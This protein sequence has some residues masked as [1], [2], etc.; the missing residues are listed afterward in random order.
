MEEIVIAI[1]VKIYL[2]VEPVQK[3]MQMVQPPLYEEIPK[4][5]TTGSDGERDMVGK[6]I[7]FTEE[8]ENY[9][10]QHN[11]SDF[12]QKFPEMLKKYGK[13]KVYGAV[14]YKRIKLTK[15]KGH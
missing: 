1:R 8:Q 12:V 6:S 4:K 10:K 9:L 15:G 13:K 3:Q 2:D 11:Y 5:D 14:F 7:P